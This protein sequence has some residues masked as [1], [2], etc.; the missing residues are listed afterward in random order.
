MKKKILLRGMLG[1]P[2]G[3]A[4]GY[5]ITIIT[6]LIWAE[7]Y[8]SPCMPALTDMMGS[9]IHAVMLQAFLCG[10]LGTGFAAGSVIWEL[11]EWGIIRQ[12]GTYFLLTSIIMMPIAY[13]T[14]WMEHSLGGVL[15]Y[16]GV[17]TVIFLFYWIV[18]YAAG[19]RNV[20]QMNEKLSRK[21]DGK[22][23]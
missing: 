10:I 23:S 18:L 2:L 1:F 17:F 5:L 11:E 13:I 4:I 19:R 9:E 15:A 16:F 8:Y 3:I 7:G 14:H 12:T 20:R 22:I 21:Q 6:S